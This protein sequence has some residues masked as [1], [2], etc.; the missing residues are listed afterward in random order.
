M[1]DNYSRNRKQTV[2]KSKDNLQLEC[3]FNAQISHFIDLQAEDAVILV[4]T[5][6]TSLIFL[7][8][9][10]ITSRY[11]PYSSLVSD[12]KLL[13]LLINSLIKYVFNNVCQ[14]KTKSSKCWIMQ[15]KRQRF[16]IF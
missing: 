16:R 3:C 12:M 9:I 10:C 4:K 6:I 8:F 1:A 5:T 15:A 11:I 7:N 13:K 14:N 2:N